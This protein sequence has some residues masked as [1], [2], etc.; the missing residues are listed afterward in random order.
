MA[1]V[2][3]EARGRF[4]TLYHCTSAANWPSIKRFGLD[5]ARAAQSSDGAARPVGHPVYLASDQDHAASYAHD[6]HIDAP[7]PWLILAVDVGH[8]DRTRLGPDDV[9][10]PDIL[11]QRRSRKSWDACT[12]TESL[13]SGQ[14]TYAG[15][16][17]PAALRM[18]ARIG[19]THAFTA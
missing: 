4:A 10:L 6:A 13:L 12:W 16:I 1:E 7:G 15:I 2:L 11:A 19:A 3:T 18:V 9:D 8:L 17:A 14:C 5:P